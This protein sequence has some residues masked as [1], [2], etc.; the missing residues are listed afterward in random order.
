MSSTRLRPAERVRRAPV[1]VIL[2]VYA[3]V[4]AYP[5]LWMVISS[6]KS[7]SEIFADPWGLPSV[8]LVQN[9][10]AAWDRGISD[11]FV[12]SVIVTIISTVATVAIAAL[13]A[14]GMVRLSSRVANIVLIVAMGGLVVAPQ[15]SLIPLYRLLDTMGLLNT[16]W[17]MILPYVAFRLPMAILLI[18]SVFLGIPRELEDAAT[19]DGCR[20]FGVFRHVY[21]PLSASV[22]TTAAVLTGY[23]AWNEFL[24]AIVYIDA[25]ALRTIP[26]G[27]MSFRDSLSTEWGVLLAGLTI[28][29]LPIVV[30]FLALQRYFVAGVAAGSVKG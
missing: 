16:Y 26:A 11:Y 12:N 3:V 17:A 20:S 30:V 10:A 27:L 1:Q 4:I 29:A 15:V 13:C 22:L 9:Y 25:D 5:L 6:F 18:R 8:W 21:L 2:A 28:A 7:S 24:F 23:F 19:I 14:Y